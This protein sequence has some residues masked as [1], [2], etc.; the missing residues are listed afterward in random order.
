VSTGPLTTGWFYS[1]L[2]EPGGPQY[3]PISWEQLAAL[4]Q[5]GAVAPGD[6]VWH[7]TLPGWLP[8][9]QIVGLFPAPIS[10]APLQAPAPPTPYGAAPGWNPPPVA[11]GPGGRRRSPLPWL[12]PLVALVLVGAAIGLFFGL[13]GGDDDRGLNVSGTTESTTAT[14]PESTTPTSEA[15]PGDPGTWLVMMYQDADDEILEEDMA[16]D[17][18]EAELVGSSAQVTIVAQ[19]DRYAGGFDGG[20]DVTST[21]RY[22]LNQDSDLYTV[23][24]QEVADL[25]E[26]DMG[27]GQTLYDFATWAISTYPAEHYVL[28]L[29][30]HGG[31]WTGGWTDNDP[32][33]GSSLSMQEIDDTIGAI[34]ADT[35]IGAFELVGFD[36]CLMGQLEVMSAI[37]PHAKYAVGSAE[38]EPSIGWSYAGFLQALTDNTAMT[39]RELGQAIVDT[40]VGQDIRITDEQARRALTGGDYTE[41]SV[42]AELSLDTTLAAFDLGTIR[43]LNSAVNGLAV[44][45]TGVDQEVVAQ[46]RAYAQSYASVFGDEDPP[47]F[48]DLGHFVDLLIE[49]A[50]DPGV[51]Q[52]AQLVKSALAQTVTAEK[53]G[54]ERPGS[55]G[56]S[57]YFPN[58]EEYVGTFG[59][60]TL[61]YPSSIGRFATASLWDDY[62]TF[63]YTG[64]TF[65][66]AAADLSVV[67]PAQAAQTDFAQAVADSAPAENVKIVAPGKGELSIAPI[68]VSASQIASDEIVTLS[69][70]ITGSNIAYVY[71]YVSY[72]WESDGSYLTADEGFIEPG[73]TKEIGGV[74]YPDWGEEGVTSVEYDWDPTLFYMSDGN[75]ANDQFAFF[76]PT[77]YGAEA[78]G[79]IYTV[80]G[81]YT[82]L[83]SGTQI[84]AEID[85]N[86]EGDMQCVWGFSDEGDGLGTWHEITPTPGDTFTI[87]CEYLEFNENPEGEF[88]D[89]PGGVMTFGDTPFTM[90][91][92]YVEPGDYALAVGVEDLDGNTTWEF[93]EITVTE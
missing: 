36:A 72:Y 78:S 62:L 59:E 68:T 85:F 86:G 50:N 11:P 22:L 34:V 69:T 41:E 56:V 64:A 7:S 4:A 91:P 20:N 23:N 66:P 76:E 51:T 26:L 81:T 63:H 18:N 87:T 65:D 90:V 8:A 57:I 80:R 83:D 74:Y 13:R 21:K 38:T 5:T 16:L 54:E 15:T 24:S 12:I 70:E 93:T 88:V 30:D 10:V 33:G 42:A 55:S 67:T 14:V 3:G 45:L 39:G 82:F 19:L 53:H 25:G 47:S 46:A 28:V 73:Y 48:I 58:S 1:K 79:D 9:A 31:G 49:D 92:Y 17:L 44:A 89:Y 71:Y 2:Q 60:W 43:E 61:N 75:D 27:D 32:V 77:I 35:G 84:D 29:S 6:P 52:A 37:A 40:Y